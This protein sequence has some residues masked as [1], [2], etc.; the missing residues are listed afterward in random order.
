MSLTVLE[1]ETTSAIQGYGP[2]REG[3]RRREASE[4]LRV[5]PQDR[6]GWPWGNSLKEGW[7]RGWADEA[8]NVTM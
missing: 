3:L 7:A 8:S 6:G 4:S 2:R 1:S 5:P